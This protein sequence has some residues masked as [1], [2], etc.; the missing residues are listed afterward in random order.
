LARF[1]TNPAPADVINWFVEPVGFNVE[2]RAKT[3]FLT[4]LMSEKGASRVDLGVAAGEFRE[5]VHMGT[6]L[7]FGLKRG[8]TSLARK[9]ERSP[10]S[11]DRFLHR[12]SK[13]GVENA[14][15]E[16][17]KKWG[18][19][20]SR[21]F[22]KIVDGWLTV[23]L[24]LK[25]LAH[26][27]YD[28]AVYLQSAVPTDGSSMINITV[29]GGASEEYSY[30][31]VL[32]EQ[33]LNGSWVQLEVDLIQSVKIDYSCVYKVPIVPTIAQQLGFDN[34]A[35][36]AWNLVRYSWLI[37]YA[38]GVGDWLASFTAANDTKFLEGTRSR[39][40]VTRLDKLRSV[41]VLNSGLTKDPANG[42]LLVNISLFD[43]ELLGGVG[44][45]P[46]AM[47]GVKSKLGLNQLANA[48]AVLKNFVR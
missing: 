32:C 47:P 44:V 25:P 18:S 19:S 33:S 31:K 34:P 28:A 29:R 13:I 48:I 26:D 43:R 17:G 20:E 35:Y 11:V 40:R 10:Q 22:E 41:D 45:T 16:M 4:N 30:S 6:D 42:P 27:I 3:K 38:F 14:L 23:Q 8:I 39:K 2:N 46:A 24:G 7:A 36:V 15:V 5:T 9:I 21:L 12:A 37:D 1:G